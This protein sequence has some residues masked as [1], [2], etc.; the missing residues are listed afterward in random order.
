MAKSNK[1]KKKKEPNRKKKVR[2]HKKKSIKKSKHKEPFRKTVKKRS[3]ATR[4]PVIKKRAKKKNPQ[5]TGFKRYSRVRSILLQYLR[6]AG[7]KPGKDIYET[8]SKIYQV[9][10]GYSLKFIRQNIER[11]Y[12]D[13]V[14]PPPPQIEFADAIPFYHFSET[15][16]LPQYD[17][18]EIS[19]YMNDQ[20]EE[21]QFTGF[22]LDVVDYYKENVHGYLRSNY[23]KS[24]VAYFKII[25]TNNI[26]FVKYNI[27]TG[28]EIGGIGAPKEPKPPIESKKTPELES[29]K[30]KIALEQAVQK[31]IK[32]KVD[33]VMSLQKAGLSI[34]EIKKYLGI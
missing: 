9:T 16:V 34:E 11:L 14:A 8:I 29:I 22:A 12:E 25:E 31:T 4:R 17:G 32:D 20:S 30:N 1:K 2:A 3:K 15:I 28:S 10:K 23:S 26:D 5:P 18:V 7:I 27:I 6:E 13:S 24:P 21:F 19:I 33:A